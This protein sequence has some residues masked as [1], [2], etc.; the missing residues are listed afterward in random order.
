MTPCRWLFSSRHFEGILCVHLLGSAGLRR[1]FVKI[2]KQVHSFSTLYE[3]R[4]LGELM[5][6]F[7]NTFFGHREYIFIRFKE[8]FK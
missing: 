2:N 6:I 7:G 8:L 3:R 1:M 5:G 4:N